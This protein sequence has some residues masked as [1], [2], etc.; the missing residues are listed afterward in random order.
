M[1][2]ASGLLPAANFLKKVQKCLGAQI[3][4]PALSRR[5]EYGEINYGLVDGSFQ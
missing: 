4:M 1:L 3:K 5:Q 2:L